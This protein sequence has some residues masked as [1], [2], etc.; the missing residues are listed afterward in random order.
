ML[1]IGNVVV[2]N[3]GLGGLFGALYR[4]AV[5][6]GTF[7]QIVAGVE[8]V[9]SGLVYWTVQWENGRRF[10]VRE[11]DI[12]ACVFGAIAYS[13][14]TRKSG[15]S[16]QAPQQAV[17]ERVALEYCAAPDAQVVVTGWNVWLALVDGGGVVGSG[18]G[19]TAAGA[20][21]NAAQS[22]GKPSQSCR[23]LALFDTRYGQRPM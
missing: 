8:M 1:S 9:P 7:G 20:H 10:H 21:Q 19:Q 13:A 18:W 16:W 17:A 22:C 6:E 23:R 4:P 14:S 3:R 5:P 2:A 11:L 15:S 12:T